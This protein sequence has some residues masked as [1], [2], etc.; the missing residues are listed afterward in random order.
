ML[1][2]LHIENIAVIELSDISFDARLNILTGETGAGK[3]IVIDALG[4]LL[5]QRASRD[6]IRSGHA[7]A[8]VSGVFTNGDE[9]SMLLRELR[10]DGRSLCRVDGKPVTLAVLRELGDG[11]V[12]I[13]GQH[14]SQALLREETH[15]T[16]L[17][18][19]AELS[20]T[21]YT[22][23]YDT[24]KRLRAERKTLSVAEDEKR[25]RID[26]LTYRL[27][28]LREI[29]PRPGEEEELSARR[30]TLRSAES[31]REALNEAYYALYGDEET[32]GACDLAREAADAVS[33]AAR[34]APDM[35]ALSERLNELQYAL[36]DCAG[37]ARGYFEGMEASEEE[38]ELAE[39]R[40]D[41]LNKLRRKHNMSIAGILE[42]GERWEKELESL[43]YADR[44]LT[45]LEGELHGA[46]DALLAEAQS[47]TGRRAEAA[48]RLEGR[49]AEELAEL[50][51]GKVR[52][53]V[54]FEQTEP[55]PSGCDGIRFLIAANVGESFKS[56][57][58]IASGGEMARIM[59]ALKNL[60]AE[61]DGVQTLVFDEV[62]SGVSGRAA[63]RVAQKLCAVSRR[64]QVL[65]VTHLPQIAAF[66][67]SHFHVEKAV[68]G[69][70][71]VTRVQKL[72]HEGRV[73][74]LARI[75]AGASVTGNTRKTAED[76][77][78]QAEQYKQA[79][80][81]RLS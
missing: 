12:N 70:R 29:D 68:E 66:A 63:Q 75:M 46:G 69:G 35:E 79:L 76:L 67:D 13:H 58:K 37:E 61:G 19:F 31:I 41:A 45:E 3:S 1:S 7:A 15:I 2:L 50:D 73:E 77:L 23:L 43:E 71:T 14:D 48:R 9:E 40:L 39:A 62:D 55:G 51:M 16:Y 20:L 49:I 10:D 6:L 74:E 8:E 27:N 5:G 65:C 60:L 17:D 26:T 24:W 4:A 81:E 22:E 78:A 56:L 47:L 30:K 33:G 54:I 18:A 36:R 25:A 72:G 28:E 59:L 11:L 21:K 44:R 52:F 38:L 53:S 32:R 80:R 42:A 57:S 64:R 34:S